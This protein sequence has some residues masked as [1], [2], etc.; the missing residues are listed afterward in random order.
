MKLRI[1]KTAVL[2]PVLLAGLSLSAF[3][4]AATPPRSVRNIQMTI[5]VKGEYGLEGRS[6]ATGRYAFTFLWSGQ[7][8]SDGDDYLLLHDRC[9]LKKWEAEEQSNGPGGSR[10]LSTGDF[11]ERPELMVRYFLKTG[12]VARVNFVIRGFAV[13]QSVPLEAFYLHLPASEENNN[14]DFGM[15]YKLFLISGSNSIDLEDADIRK[16]DVEK[17][18]HWAWRYRT[19]VQTNIHEANV[20]IV[21]SNPQK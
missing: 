20:K 6:R 3:P 17:T 8:E 9:D 7:I 21:I 5:T 14:R 4:Q 16:G 1:R 12:D 13:P 2:L 15:N 11:E 10:I 19:V 18:F